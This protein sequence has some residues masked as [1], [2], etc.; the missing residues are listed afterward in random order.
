MKKFVYGA[1]VFGLGL[2][3]L[4][5][6]SK[7][8]GIVGKVNGQ[9]VE[10]VKAFYDQCVDGTRDAVKKIS[11]PQL[12]AKTASD[13]LNA[14]FDK[15]SPVIAGR[16]ADLSGPVSTITDPLVVDKAARK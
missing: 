7:M 2:C 10:L 6:S 13:M 4:A 12:K 14:C 16:I 15:F 3:A 11:D 5:C 9:D 8:L 1:V